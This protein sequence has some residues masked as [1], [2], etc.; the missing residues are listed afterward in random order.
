LAR[1]WILSSAGQPVGVSI[2]LGITDGTFSEVVSG[3]LKEGAELIVEEAPNKK[4]Q[5]TNTGR[6]PFMPGP[7]K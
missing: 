3:D 4:A 6:L 5:T 1:V 7:R 2:F